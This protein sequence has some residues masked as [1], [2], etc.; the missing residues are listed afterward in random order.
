[1]K[2]RIRLFGVIEG[3]PIHAE[4]ELALSKGRSLKKIL[5]QA[6]TVLG[7]E[8]PGTLRKILKP[9]AQAALLLQ[10]DP[11]PFPEG[12]DYQPADGDEITILLPLAGG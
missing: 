5:K 2:I 1:M 10:G 3:K 11:L 8:K 7:L 6:D 9:G 4:G 12:L